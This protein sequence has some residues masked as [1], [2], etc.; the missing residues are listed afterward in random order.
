MKRMTDS[1]KKPKRPR[2]ANQLAK[3][4]ADLA[5]GNAADVDPDSEKNP[6]AVSL[7]RAGGLGGN[8]RAKA[9]ATEKRRE[10][11]KKAAKSRWDKR[12]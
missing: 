8:A 5:T 10:I 9:L 11:A 6:H 2:D 12:E 4:I 1:A 3:M 7:G